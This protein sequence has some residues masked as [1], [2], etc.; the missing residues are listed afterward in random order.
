MKEELINFKGIHINLKNV[1]SIYFQ[2]S[3][4]NYMADYE[5]D[6]YIN[7][8]K[9]NIEERIHRV[10]KDF[11]ELLDKLNDVNNGE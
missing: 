1:V 10:K 9:H 5:T 8:I 3:R 4:A 2:E 7:G 6:M 11:D